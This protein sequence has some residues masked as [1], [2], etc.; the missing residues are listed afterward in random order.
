MA[1]ALARCGNPVGY[2]A[3]PPGISRKILLQKMDNSAC[4]A[5]W[6]KAPESPRQT[7]LRP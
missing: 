4:G 7:W 3:T 6:V 5:R 1:R 2:T